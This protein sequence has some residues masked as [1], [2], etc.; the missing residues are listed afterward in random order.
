M[1]ARM[2]GPELALFIDELRV[3]LD[4]GDL[5]ALGSVALRGESWDLDPSRELPGGFAVDERVQTIVTARFRTSSACHQGRGGSGRGRSAPV[6]E[7][8]EPNTQGTEDEVH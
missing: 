7:E 4:D 2:T 8:A 3:L 1:A 6:R 5:A